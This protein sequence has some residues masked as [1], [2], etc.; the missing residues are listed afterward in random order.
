M[1]GIT[2]TFTH[3]CTV[4]IVYLLIAHP[5]AAFVMFPED[6]RPTVRYQASVLVLQKFLKSERLYTGPLSG[7]YDSE[8]KRAVIAF[9]QKQRI[10]PTDG[11]F[12]GKTRLTANAIMDRQITEYQKSAKKPAPAQQP[13]QTAAPAQTTQ[14]IARKSCKIAD[15]L[16]L[17]DATS[18][19]FYRYPVA[20][21]G[22]TCIS[23]KRTCT[24]GYADGDP[25]YRY[26]TCVEK[27]NAPVI[28]PDPASQKKSAPVKST[29]PTQSP[30]KDGTKKDTQ[31]NADRT[32]RRTA[33]A[34]CETPVARG[35][36]TPTNYGPVFFNAL[37]S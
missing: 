27:K 20:G 19:I 35:S 12:R 6:L 9:Q 26:P 28:I 32:T 31:S 7:Y 5:A 4:L 16:Y 37:V 22:G 14:P 1:H 30:A 8:T 24:D 34:T 36:H 29:T 17:K 25:G 13:Q 33:F 2:R 3:V 15:E 18:K 21:N 11:Q 10:T 23:M